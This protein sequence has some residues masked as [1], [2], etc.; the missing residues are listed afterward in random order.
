MRGGFFT[1][2]TCHTDPAD[3]GPRVSRATFA[4]SRTDEAPHRAKLRAGSAQPRRPSPIPLAPPS[5]IAPDPA[6]AGV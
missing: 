6:A 5:D 4:A 3:T 1:T 2:G